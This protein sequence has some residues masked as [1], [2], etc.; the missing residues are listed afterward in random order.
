M[1]KV[2]LN[3]VRGAADPEDTEVVTKGGS[4]HTV[5]YAFRTARRC[6]DERHRKEENLGVRLKVSGRTRE[7]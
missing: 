3:P 4:L 6:R 5:G 1:R 2:L 7:V